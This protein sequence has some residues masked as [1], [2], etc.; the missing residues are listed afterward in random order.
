MFKKAD[1]NPKIL[2]VTDKL[3]TG[4]DAPLLYCIYL[5]KP[6]RDHVL[7]QAIARV[8][9]PYVDANGAS[10]RIGLVVDYVGV[11]GALEKAL[12]FDSTDVSGVIEDLDLLLADLLIKLGDAETKYLK[13]EGT[14][15]ADRILERI[16][17]GRF[18]AKE[19]RAAFFEDYKEI[20]ALWEILSPSPE[21]RDHI[22]TYKQLAELY[23]I[24]RN[25][26]ADNVNDLADLANKTQTMLKENATQRGLVLAQRSATFDVRTV[27]QSPRPQ[28]VRS[29]Q[30]H[31]AA[32][33][34][35]LEVNAGR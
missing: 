2:I 7:L 16:V 1:E 4:C 33:S 29:H 11:L 12:R 23:A 34:V 26:Y 18:L 25:A 28:P 14:G 3:L 13:D 20:E 9:R 5:D 22:D 15:G 10:K 24:V 35:Q 21:L 8:N 19:S 27:R 17:Y 31:S 30:P 32:R 6:M